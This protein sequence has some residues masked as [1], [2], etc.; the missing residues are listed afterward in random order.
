MNID[1][2]LQCMNYIYADTIK[3]NWNTFYC[4]ICI[5]GNINWGV[6]KVCYE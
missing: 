2:P 1:N 6:M 4:G 3:K 5:P